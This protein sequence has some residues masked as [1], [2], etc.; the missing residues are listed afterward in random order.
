MFRPVPKMPIRVRNSVLGGMVPLICVPLMGSTCESVMEEVKNLPSG[1]DVIELRIDAWDAVEDL[2]F[3]VDLIGKVRAAVGDLPLILTCRGHWEGGLNGVSELAK[4]RIYSRAISEGLV[5]FVDKE[6]S[7]GY[8]KIAEVKAHAEAHGVKLIVSYHDF[9]RT[10]SLSF[11]YSQLVSQIRLGADVAKVAMMPSLE[12]DVLRLFEATL[13][14]RRDFPDVPLVTMS[15]GVLGQVS[16]LVGGLYGSDLT[17]AVGSA[18]SAP[19]Q[20]SVDAV[21]TAFDLIYGR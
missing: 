12:E 15:M 18:P 5:D 11:I 17:F 3:S 10:P 21:R 6:M 16:R 20:P 4:D 8:G 9:E 1:T 7:Y 19:G 13:A 2:E 14:V